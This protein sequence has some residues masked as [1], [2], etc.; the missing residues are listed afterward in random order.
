MRTCRV[1]RS[2]VIFD[3]DGTLADSMSQL[4]AA[5]SAQFGDRLSPGQTMELL[6]LPAPRMFEA[7]VERTGVPVAELQSSFMA[8]AHSLPT[9]V[10]PE[11]PDVLTALHESGYRLVLSTTTPA[12]SLPA[13][14]EAANL[15]AYFDLAL[16][17]DVG[18]G[19]TK[20]AHPG[21]VA[22]H[23]DLSLAELSTVAAYVGDLP[24]DM[25]LARSHGLLGIARAGASNANDLLAAGA[26]HIIENLTELEPLLL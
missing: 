25:I 16:G 17:S 23:F 18:N 12:F 20:E 11:V 24:G 10:F 13:R 2:V 8:V 19:M 1:P 9:V 22:E 21:L 7:F 4:V 15:S 3:L 5:V 26:D 14:L 6:R